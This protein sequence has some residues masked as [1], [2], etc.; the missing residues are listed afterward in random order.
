MEQW[1]G[2]LF[3]VEKDGTLKLV[4]P[5]SQRE[6]LIADLHGGVTGAHLGPEKTLGRVRTHY[7]W[8][9]IHRDVYAQCRG[10]S[11]CRSRKSGDAPI[12]PLKPIPVGRTLGMCWR[13]CAEAPTKSLRKG[14]PGSLPRLSNEVARGVPYNQPRHLTIARLL[15]E[16]VVPVHGV[17][18]SDRGGC[19]LSNLMAE[20]YRLLSI[21]KVNT[22]AYHPQSDGMVERMN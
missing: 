5:T 12:V 3:R 19:F 1:D 14:L 21:T 22:T 4:P 7:W 18:L 17:L 15:V 8:E 13:G 6:K 16:R 10:C 20:L 11:V 2:V 9:T